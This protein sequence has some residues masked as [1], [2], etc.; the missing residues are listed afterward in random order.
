MAKNIQTLLVGR[1]LDG[2]A[3][4]AFLSVA[5][6]TV[7]DLFAPSQIQAP[8][9]LYAASPFLGPIFGPLIGGFINQFTTWYAFS[10][11][12]SYAL[13]NIGSYPGAGRFIF[14]SSGQASCWCAFFSSLKHTTQFFSTEKRVPY[15]KLLAM[16]HTT[17]LPSASGHRNQ[18]LV[19]SW[20]RLPS[21]SNSCSWNPCACAYVSTRLLSSEFCTSSLVPSHWFSEPIMALSS[22][23]RASHSS[24]LQLG[25]WQEFSPIL[26]GIKITSV[27]CATHINISKKKRCD[28][29]RIRNSAY[30]QLF[31]ELY[32]FR[33]VCFGSGG[34]ATALYIGLCLSLA[35]CSL[36]LGKLSH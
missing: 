21:P 1:F 32:L 31:L 24:V 13:A 34:L 7:A 26:C 20:A 2:I 5:A 28:Q 9:M 17:Q 12:T 18:S 10:S 3:G 33:W 11:Y 27:L 16:R 30:L 15:A 8:M 6:G 4:S 25:C 19:P 29:N 22:G 36:V 35:V 14:F 23:R